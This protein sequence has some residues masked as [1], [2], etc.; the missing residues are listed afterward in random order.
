VK[1]LFES[2]VRVDKSISLGD[3]INGINII[4]V[5]KFYALGW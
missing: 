5:A 1:I 3:E 2:V 4:M